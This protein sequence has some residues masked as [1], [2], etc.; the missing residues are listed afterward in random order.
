[1]IASLQRRDADDFSAAASAWGS[2]VPMRRISFDQAQF[3]LPRSR[4]Q[5]A[6][7][8]IVVFAVRKQLRPCVPRVTGQQK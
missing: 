2:S 5:S 1:V 4:M 6:Q 7:P 3:D 8:Y